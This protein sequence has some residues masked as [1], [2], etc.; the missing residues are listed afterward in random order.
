MRTLLIL[1]DGV[2]MMYRRQSARY[3]F[4]KP[5]NHSAKELPVF[6]EEEIEDQFGNVPKDTWLVC[7]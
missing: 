1:Q 5:C 2:E 6:S 4:I 7:G 3:Q